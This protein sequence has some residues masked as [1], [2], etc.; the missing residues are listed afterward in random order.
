MRRRTFLTAVGATSLGVAACNEAAVTP[1]T[2]PTLVTAHP[3]PLA[4]VRTGATDRIA[5]SAGLSVELDP[6]LRTLRGLGVLGAEWALEGDSNEHIR[7]PI[8]AC[9]WGDQIAVID[10]SEGAVVVV[11]S[12][13]TIERTLGADALVRPL[14]AT[15]LEDGRLAVVDGALHAIITLDH[16]GRA[17]VLAGG[18]ANAPIEGPLN[19]PRSIAVAP[20]GDLHVVDGGGARVVIFAASGREVGS[21]GSVGDGL[22]SP[23]TITTDA[24]GRSFV[25]DP[26]AGS[27]FVFAGGTLRDRWDAPT[28]DGQRGAPLAARLQADGSLFVALA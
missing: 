26:V 25:A 28:V 22:M 1:T 4:L 5:I 20:N 8:A 23:R 14:A 16:S 15:A 3:H 18:H 6:R 12:N 21:Y 11:G 24:R 2:G 13:G 10:A 9:A 19:G 7:S 17:E 27:V